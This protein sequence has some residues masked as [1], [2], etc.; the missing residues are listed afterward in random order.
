MPLRIEDYTIIGDRR[1]AALVGDDGSIDWLCLPRFDSP[2]VSGALLGYGDHGAWR[3]APRT[4]AVASR[5]YV[6]DTVVLRQH[7]RTSTGAVTVTDAMTFSGGRSHVVRR[8]SGD[9]GVVRMR[10]EVTF[11]F[12]YASATPWVRQERRDGSAVLVATAGPDAL[13]LRG[14]ELRAE[15]MRH[16]TEFDVRAGGDRR[17]RAELVRLPRA[18]ARAHRGRRRARRG[19]DRLAAL[20]PAGE[21]TGGARARGAPI[22]RDAPS[23]HLPRHGRYRRGRHDEPAGTHRRRPQLGLPVRVAPRRIAHPRDAPAPRPHPRG[24]PVARMAA[25]RRRGG[26]RGRPHRLRPRGRTRSPRAGDR[27]AARLPWLRSRPHRERRGVAVP[28]GRVR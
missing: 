12:G 2:S 10:V 20:D 14:P 22:A 4:D 1:T 21:R 13:V 3:I 18:G 27:L 24:D 11:R 8:I 6:E 9:R 7:W 28:G 5:A 16:V 25:A 15:G 19:P 17:L 23:T 26:A